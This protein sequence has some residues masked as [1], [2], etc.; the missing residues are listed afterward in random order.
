MKTKAIIILQYILKYL[1]RLT[2]WRYRPAI[3]A[4]TGSAGKTSTK[5]TI[6]AVLGSERQVRFSPGNF[7]N[8]LGL[9]LT[10][11]GEWDEIRG[12]FFWPKVI[13]RS[14]LNL[15]IRQEYPEIL[16]LECGVDRPGDM[17]HLME[18]FRPNISV[19]TSIGDVPVHVEFFSGP[20]ALAREKARL[21][22]SLPA[23][24]VAVLNA[25]DETVMRFEDRTRAQIITYGVSKK[26]DVRVANFEYRVVGGEPLGI[27]FALQYGGISFPVQ[28]NGV[29]GKG[30]AYAAAA[31]A[32]VGLVFGIHLSKIAETLKAYAPAK[33]RMQLLTGVKETFVID[34]SYNASPLSMEAALEALKKLPGKRKIAVLGDMLE[35]GKYALEAHED[36]GR[37]AAQAVDVL[38]TVG[39]RSKFMAEAA[40]AAGINKK[41]VLSFDSADDARLPVQD[42]IKKGDLVLVKASR[43]IHLEK[44]VEEI[45]MR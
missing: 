13:A 41:N 38:V 3:V 4:V 42:L 8:A 30:Q 24:G 25:D 18:I 36:I 15:I 32:A 19:I 37:L 43:G 1:A 6:A 28:F 20:E 21:V 33:S 31:A 22:E 10:I 45:K 17:K 29:F 12:I 5:L 2:L 23:A 44:I 14:I 26:A 7:N 34:D 27:S 11:L 16:V 9:P 35:L 39:P 40:M